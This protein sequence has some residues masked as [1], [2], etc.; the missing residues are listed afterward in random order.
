MG[1]CTGSVS[2]CSYTFHK[3]FSYY[4]GFMLGFNQASSSLSFHGSAVESVSLA[5]PSSVVHPT[6]L[7]PPPPPP[8]PLLL[9][10]YMKL[11]RGVEKQL[12]PPRVPLRR[13]PRFMG[14][15][16]VLAQCRVSMG[17]ASNSA[18][19]ASTSTSEL[20]AFVVVAVAVAAP[21]RVSTQSFCRLCSVS[22]MPSAVP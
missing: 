8:P 18:H 11:F 21:P 1:S 2:M 6:P 20:A 15:D 3:A 17:S 10:V 5:G 12:E 7:P 13:C 9:L 22:W 14:E 16:E 4:I 19:T